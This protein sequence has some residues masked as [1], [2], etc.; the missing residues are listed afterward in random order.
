M[1]THR[2]IKQRKIRLLGGFTEKVEQ[3]EI[4]GLEN[5]GYCVLSTRLSEEILSLYD[6]DAPPVRWLI[7]T[8]LYVGKQK[9]KNKGFCDWLREHVKGNC[10]T[11]Q[12]KLGGEEMKG[13]RPEKKEWERQRSEFF[14]SHQQKNRWGKTRQLDYEA[15]ADAILRELLGLDTWVKISEDGDFLIAP[16]FTPQDWRRYR[17]VFIE[18]EE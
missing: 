10:L 18:E 4:Q 12:G 5:E 16:A 15:G 9:V 11:F 2:I 13:W 14:E 8:Y 1:A 6:K 17:L 3:F 7:I